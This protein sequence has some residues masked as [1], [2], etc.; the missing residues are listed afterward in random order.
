MKTP[1]DSMANQLSKALNL[2]SDATGG[3]NARHDSSDTSSAGKKGGKD[4]DS[5]RITLEEDSLVY[6]S[7]L[8]KCALKLTAEERKVFMGTVMKTHAAQAKTAEA[9]ASSAE[10][11]VELE[12][13]KVREVDAN[14]KLKEAQVENLKAQSRTAWVSI[15]LGILGGVSAGVGL[16][17]AAKSGTKKDS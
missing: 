14:I 3:S 6:N 15:V 16:I 5:P 12:R 1:N 8:G 11:S 10:V 7:S 2:P 4:G 9:S 13:A 17:A